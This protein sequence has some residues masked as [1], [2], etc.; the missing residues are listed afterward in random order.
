[1]RIKE[2]V[3]IGEMLRNFIAQNRGIN[4]RFENHEEMSPHFKLFY[5]L[6]R[7]K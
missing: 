6:D 5:S 7:I 3:L 4:K 1:M 2:T